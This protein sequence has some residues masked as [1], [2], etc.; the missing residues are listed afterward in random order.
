M[1]VSMRGRVGVSVP[2][3]VCVREYVDVHMLAWECVSVCVCGSVCICVTAC[4][5]YVCMCACRLA[6]ACH[7]AFAS[8]RARFILSC[9]WT[10]TMEKT[11]RTTS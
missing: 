5:L 4:A 3:P 1:G 9:D 6:F 2:V 7:L 10:E 11:D 8:R